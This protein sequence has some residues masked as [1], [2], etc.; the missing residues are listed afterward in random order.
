M[1]PEQFMDVDVNE[2]GAF[3]DGNIPLLQGPCEDEVV[4]GP[5][6]VPEGVPAEFS[7]CYP[8]NR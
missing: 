1:D 6:E 7:L 4:L 2:G 3:R 8:W 5:P